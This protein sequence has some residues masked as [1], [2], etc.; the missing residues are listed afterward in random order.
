MRKNRQIRSFKTLLIKK[1][2][3]L[4]LMRVRIINL[5]IVHDNQVAQKDF[6]V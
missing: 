2:G 6:K 3:T 4:L 5:N 1:N